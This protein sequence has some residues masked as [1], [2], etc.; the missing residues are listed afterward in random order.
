[1]E[2]FLAYK[3][4]NQSLKVNFGT[5]HYSNVLSP[6]GFFVSD[7]HGQKYWN[8]ETKRASHLGELSISEQG[9][10]NVPIISR[11]DYLSHCESIVNE[12]KLM[13]LQK[14]VYSRVKTVDFE[15]ENFKSVFEDLCFNY[16]NNLNYC[17]YSSELG[18]WM[19]S[20]P[21]ILM[22]G[23]KNKFM[24]MALAGTLP[25]NASDDLWTNK[26]LEEQQFVADYLEKLIVEHGQLLQKSERFVHQV[27]PVK[28]LR[29]DFEFLI[30]TPKIVDFIRDFHP[31]PAVCGVPKESS[32]I[33]YENYELHK[34][35]LYTGIIG[36]S[37]SNSTALFVN[38]RCMQLFDGVAALYVGGGLTKHSIP[39]TEWL[40]TE[41]K[42]DALSNF[43]K[44]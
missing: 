44:R 37:D 14:V 11:S 26:E 34:R 1:M 20:T 10:L 33:C 32:R 38:L 5:W 24:S 35:S 7:A 15:L 16:P 27:G 23:E 8:F 25:A 6:N 41:R 39:T 22:Q 36:Y 3:I 2:E 40:E 18:F 30:S 17:L 12:L 31:T 19:G 21:E 28:H 13:Q 9:S 43:L 42:A 29:N 4:P